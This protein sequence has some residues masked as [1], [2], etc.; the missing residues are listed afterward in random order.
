MSLVVLPDRPFCVHV[1][2]TAEKI[3]LLPLFLVISDTCCTEG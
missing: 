2:R 3:K 1:V